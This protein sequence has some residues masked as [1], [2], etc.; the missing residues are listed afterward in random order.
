M[1][2]DLCLS[3]SATLTQRIML[4]LLTRLVN[5][6]DQYRMKLIKAG[7]Q[8]GNINMKDISEHVFGPLACFLGEQDTRLKGLG[9]GI[10]SSGVAKRM[11]GWW[12]KTGVVRGVVV[13]AKR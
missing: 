3:P 6:P 7:Y 11:F 5:T 13:V 1:A 8:P 4:D 10:G 9:L 2:F 12:G